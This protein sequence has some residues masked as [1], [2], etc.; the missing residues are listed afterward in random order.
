[1]G[2]LRDAIKRRAAASAGIARPRA[3]TSSLSPPGPIVRLRGNL[4]HPARSIRFLAVERKL[5]RNEH[6][7]SR[8]A[9]RPRDTVVAGAPKL[10]G[11]KQGVKDATAFVDAF[12]ICIIFE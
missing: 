3:F 2:Q 1:M 10:L 11:R 8:N 6:F 9:H 12:V 7:A 4:D 5:R